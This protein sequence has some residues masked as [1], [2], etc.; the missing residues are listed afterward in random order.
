MEN[1]KEIFKEKKEEI[2]L[3]Y[4]FCIVCGKEGTLFFYYF[5]YEQKSDV[6][7]LAKIVGFGVDGVGL[8]AG[9]LLN[10]KYLI[11]ATFCKKCGK[12]LERLDH[13]GQ[14]FGLAF[15][16][17]I[18]VFLLLA[19]Y[20]SS[21]AGMDWSIATFGFGIGL[22]IL[23]IFIGRF[24]VSRHSPRMKKVDKEK[25]ILKVPGKGILTYNRIQATK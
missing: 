21:F 14:L 5:E 11:T 13:N 9:K 16:L 3:P 10:K 7:R 17:T 1:L 19:M 2:T 18:F 15:V 8:I 22:A 6:A 20:V 23:V 24:Y 4:E 12:K 25:V